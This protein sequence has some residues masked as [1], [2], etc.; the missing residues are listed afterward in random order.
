MRSDKYDWQQISRDLRS[1]SCSLME[2]FEVCGRSSAFNVNNVLVT[3]RPPTYVS[4]ITCQLYFQAANVLWIFRIFPAVYLVRSAAIITQQNAAV[5]GSSWSMRHHFS[6]T[7]SGSA[8]AP[9]LR[10]IHTL[11][12][13]VVVRCRTASCGKSH[14]N[15]HIQYNPLNRIPLNCITRLFE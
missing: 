7:K 15:M 12:D 5:S 14:M 4:N 9:H 1:Q 3:N 10:P 13:V 2:S 6:W 11:H 8:G